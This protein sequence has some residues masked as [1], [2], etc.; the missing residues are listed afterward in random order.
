MIPSYSLAAPAP[1]LR[2]AAAPVEVAGPG[3]AVQPP[4]ARHEVCTQ[5]LVIY[6]GRP[7]ALAALDVVPDGGVGGIADTEEEE[8]EEAHRGYGGQQGDLL[9]RR[10]G[11]CCD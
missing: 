4:A 8:E 9:R 5:V 3:W 10:L 1:L 7:V 2:F 11:H 6:E